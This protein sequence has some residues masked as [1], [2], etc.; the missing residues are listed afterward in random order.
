L[1]RDGL[2]IGVVGVLMDDVSP[3]LT[4]PRLFGPN[5]MLPA[6]DT[7]RAEA[8]KL[9]DKTD[10][11]IALVHLTKDPCDEIVSN[12]PDYAITI[13]GH[14][15]V[16]KENMFRAEDRV[17]VRLRSYGSELGRLNI[18]YDKAT[19]KVL[20]ADWKR[21]PIN[22][23]AF[24]PD[25]VVAQLVE[26][27]ESKVRAVVDSPIG[28]SSAAKDRPQ[29]KLWIERVMRETTGAHCLPD[30][31]LPAMYGIS[32]PSTTSWWSAAFPV[33]Y[34]QTLSA[35]IQLLSLTSFMP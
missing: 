3:N 2:R 18:R 1:N 10:I 15:H 32:C 28:Q 17:G 33:V 20:S 27:W 31:F 7:L 13:S 12:I 19:K 11:L 9:K 30:K 21:I 8:A 24:Q 34:S 16:G 14:D 5:R 22:T 25:P 4:S 29:T 35:A 6:L 23:T 26:K